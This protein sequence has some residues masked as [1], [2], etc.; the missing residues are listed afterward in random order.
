MPSLLAHLAPSFL[1]F[2]HQLQAFIY[3]DNLSLIFFLF[4]IYF[5]IDTAIKFQT[6]RALRLAK[7][8]K[9]NRRQ[10]WGQDE[11]SG[12]HQYGGWGQE[13]SPAAITALTHHQKAILTLFPYT[14]I[15]TTGKSNKHENSWTES[16]IPAGRN[17]LFKNYR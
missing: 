14:I 12:H 5:P 4:A 1:S 9:G 2:Q 7:I 10:R 8:G 3:T 16:K 11:S 6:G 17:C 13:R 15:Q